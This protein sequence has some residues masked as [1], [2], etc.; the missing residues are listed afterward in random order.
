MTRCIV[1]GYGWAGMHHLRTVADSRLA[2]LAG[3][4]EPD[5]QKASRIG[6][7]FDVPVYPCLSDVPPDGYDTAIIATRPPLHKEQCLQMISARKNI[8]CEKPVCRN[9]RD[10]EALRQAAEQT[11]I[12]VGVVFNQ[13]Y[14]DAVCKAKELLMQ[15][16]GAMH[17]ITASMYQHL[18]TKLGG[19]IEEDFMITDACCHLLDLVTFLAG[20]VRSV[21]AIASKNESELYSDLVAAIVFENDCIGVIS[22]SNVGGKMETQHP[23][24]CIDIHTQNARYQIENQ[25]DRLTVYPHDSM[26]QQV[27]TTSVFQER[28]YGV[29]MRRAC[30]DFLKAVDEGGEMPADLNQALTNMRILE[31]IKDSITQKE[32]ER[33]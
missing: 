24:Q 27:Y 7:E 19:G 4:V 15:D 30:E 26:A 29:S 20:N 8:L 9:S 22:H 16:N 17:L 2:A 10:I 33:P 28:D 18:P 25:Y 6:R 13:R 32:E 1:V 3:V 14:G 23:F 12:R 21:N 31:S 11:G 5:P